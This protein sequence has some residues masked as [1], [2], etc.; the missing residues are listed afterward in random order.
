MTDP[1][2]A[3]DGE[4]IAVEVAI[5]DEATADRVLFTEVLDA[6]ALGG[7]KRHRDGYLGGRVKAARTGVQTYTGSEVGWPERERVTVYRPEAEV[8]RV[9]S[10]ASYKGKPITDGHPTERVTAKNWADLSRG[11][12]MGVQRSGQDVE[13]D[14][15]ISDQGLIDKVEGN[16]ARQLSG[17]YTADIHRESGTTPDGQLYDAVQ[18][19]IYIDH[20]AVVRAGRAGSEFR[21]G[22]EAGKWGAA[23]ITKGGQKE[24]TM[25]DALKTVVLGDKAA[26]VAVSDAAIIEDYKA[27]KDREIKDAADANAKALADKNKELATADAKI[28]ELEGKVL[29]DEDKA[30]LVKDRVTLET[31]AK[32]IAPDVVVDGLTDK[33]VRLAV[34]A[35]RL[36]DEKVD[37]KD[38]AYISAMF[39]VQ[40]DVTPAQLTVDPV[41]KAMS[42]GVRTTDADPWAFL[43]QKGA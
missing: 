5:A 2:I 29:T 16:E 20:I 43:D 21:I 8:M 1:R 6:D 40:A 23:P 17:G 37:G 41:A 32:A 30:K 33:Q 9:D 38:D 12:I 13:I 39:D 22:D 27:A 4:Q 42:G 11:T 24:K 10:L 28:K 34:V 35:A 7:V 15:T 14:L 3:E 18:K 19:D 36:G 31:K 26:Q 25:T